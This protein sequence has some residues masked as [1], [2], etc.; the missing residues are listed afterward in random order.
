[1][2]AAGVLTMLATACGGS[3]GKTVEID[4]ELVF[5]PAKM[6]VKIG[7]SVTW[8]N[9]GTGMVHTATCDPAK[10]VDP[11]HVARPDGADPWDS[12]LIQRGQSWTHAFTVPGEY[13]YCC[14]PHESAG[15]VGTVVVTAKA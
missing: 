2:G 3:S 6:T 7:E 13:R 5:H 10:V 8:R 12:G 4:D 9:T 1:M 11:S 15:M 14:V